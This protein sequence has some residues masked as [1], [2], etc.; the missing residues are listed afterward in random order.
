MARVLF[1]TED[2]PSGLNGT[3]L[4]T[5]YTLK[6]LLKNGYEIDLC[7]AYFNRIIDK[8]E[9]KNLKSFLI[10]KSYP[11]K[12]SLGYWWR[13]FKLFFSPNPFFIQRLYEPRLKKLVKKL[14][15]KNNYEFVIYDGFSTL[16]YRSKTEAE[17]IYID[18]EDITDL[19]KQRFKSENNLIKK[20]SLYLNFLKSKSYEKQHLTQ[21]DQV[22]AISPET[23]KRLKSLTLARTLLMPTYLP[24]A[25]N[26]FNSKST[27]LVFTGT[28][29]WLENVAGLK[30]FLNEHWWE[31]HRK[32]PELVLDIIGR[33]A[34]SEFV[35]FLGHF[36][37]V[38]HHGYVKDLKDFYQQ[39]ALAIAPVL[40]NAGIKVK[41]LTYLSYGLPVVATKTSALG[42]VCTDGV[43]VVKKENFAKQVIGLLESEDVRKKMSEE[44]YKNLKNNYSAKQLATF[45]ENSLES[46]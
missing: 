32:F 20:I 25:K 9:S 16:I 6:W 15:T 35:D 12:Y 28:L 26:V 7:C 39:S 19:L 42:L 18:D 30:W 21:V 4:K 1:I 40:I 2:Y 13:I 23:R 29:S 43:R 11:T 46:R 45:I 37:Q 33:E 5:R 36:P 3:S 31:I 17:K 24:V 22:W 14:L 34:N 41:I 10:K 8:L 44:G 38:E 27:H